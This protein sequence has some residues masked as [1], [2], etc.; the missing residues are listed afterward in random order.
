MSLSVLSPSLATSSGDSASASALGADRGQTVLRLAMLLALY[1]IVPVTVALCPVADPDLWW[2]LR[3]GQWVVEHGTVPTTDPFSFP[4]QDHPWIAYSWLFEVVV[5]GFFSGLGLTG[6][7]ILRVLLGLAV[8]AALHRLVARREPRFLVAVVLT[9]VGTLTISPLFRERPWLFTILF[10]ILTLDVVL[11]L[12]Q[13]R[14]TRLVWLLPV[15][16]VVWA[17]VHIQFVYGLFILGLACAAPL[18]D[19]FLDRGEAGPTAATAFSRAWWSLVT[20]TAACLLASLVNPY[21][22]RLY[23][24]VLEYATQPGPYLVINELRALEFRQPYDWCMLGLL[25]AAFFALGRRR[26]LSSFEVLLL[27]AAGIFVFR[28]RRDI[29]FPVIVSLA[30]L[31]GTCHGPVPAEQ[32]FTPSRRQ[33]LLLSASL[34]LFVLV[35]AWS[36]HLSEKALQEQV[37]VSF[38][39]HAAQAIRARGLTGPLYNDFDWGGYLIWALPELPVFIDGRTNLH[40][41]ERILRSMS[42]CKGHAGWHD[43]PELAAAGVAL[44][45]AKGALGELLRRDQRFVLVYED[46]IALVFCRSK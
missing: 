34:A 12:R 9:A 16:F 3:T 46:P 37:G 21:H 13:G 8:V 26:G 36:R 19:R 29:W 45:D 44:V 5:H 4:G 2:H 7:L 42:T 32:R 24:V 25:C 31:A 27:I 20:L 40:G 41:D 18:I 15:L 22:I 43:D 6:I 30:I 11:D 28:A 1:A 14:R 17:N 39:V 35:C 10:A 38:P 33:W 23:G